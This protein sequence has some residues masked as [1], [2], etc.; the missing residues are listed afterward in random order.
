MKSGIQKRSQSILNYLRVSAETFKLKPTNVGKRKRFH[1]KE[2]DVGHIEWIRQT[3][4]WKPTKQIKALKYFSITDWLPLY[5][6]KK[7]INPS[8]TFNLH[9]SIQVDRCLPMAYKTVT[10]IIII[11]ISIQ[12]ITNKLPKHS[13][14]WGEKLSGDLMISK[15][16][17]VVQIWHLYLLLSVWC[18]W[19]EY[20]Q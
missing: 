15:Y 19:L 13:F 3:V 11:L 18:C 17:F 2:N 12:E 16:H 7:K 5:L 10:D 1:I 6:Q 20:I 9:G 4:E 8:A 14:R